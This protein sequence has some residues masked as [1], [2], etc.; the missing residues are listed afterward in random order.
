M[1]EIARAYKSQSRG[2]AGRAKS[3][4]PDEIKAMDRFLEDG[5]TDESFASTLAAVSE[6]RVISRMLP[7]SKTG[8]TVTNVAGKGAYLFS[9]AEQM[10]RRVV[11]LAAYR[12]A[13]QSGLDHEAA[14]GVAREA[15]E[16]TQF[17]Y[18]NWNRPAFMR[19]KASVIFLFYQF[20][21]N[22]LYFAARDP[23]NIRYL[24]ILLGAAG[25]QGLPFAEDLLDI[26]DRVFSSKNK[27]VDSRKEI[28]E[29]V[30]E[31]GANPDLIM[32]GASRFGLGIPW[33]AR[34][35][36]LPIPD[37]DISASLS[38]GRP[39]RVTEPLLS[40]TGDFSKNFPEAF[41]A[42]GGA[43]LSLPLEAWKIL[44]SN[45]PWTAKRMENVM[46]SMFRSVSKAYRMLSQG[47]ETTASGVPLEKFDLS[48]P[49]DLTG[50]GMQAIGFRPTALAQE[51]EKLYTMRETV[52]FYKERRQEIMN[53]LDHAYSV[54]DKEYIKDAIEAVQRY[55]R[56]VPYKLMS[57]TGSD[58][59]NSR[60]GRIKGRITEGE[61][62]LPFG[63]LKNVEVMKEYSRAFPKQGEK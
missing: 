26:F 12:L 33:V 55:N 21:Q 61:T 56:E 19:G 42:A 31:L 52:T 45:E 15:I 25:L 8:R 30:T 2:I 10:N 47:Q 60:M 16:K 57:I 7:Q 36:S 6:G 4:T 29:F 24:A 51:Q 62:G 50:I 35:A 37:F 63:S 20:L 53:Y 23:G 22:S 54:G 17:E 43:L 27:K 32:H 58:I 18:A 5:L 34:Q 41:Q 49:Q 40:V 14:Y 9:M 46:P 1:K 59:V 44:D 39:L 38:M 28:R 13:R 48:D 11:A 3:L